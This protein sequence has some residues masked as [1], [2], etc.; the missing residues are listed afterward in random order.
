MVLSI[1]DNGIHPQVP[2]DNDVSPLTQ[3][4]LFVDAT[5]GATV[6]VADTP[7]LPWLTIQAA[8]TAAVAGDKIVVAPGAYAES[9]VIDKDLFI[10]AAGVT[11]LTAAPDIS[12]GTLTGRL[13]KIAYSANGCIVYGDSSDL[14]NGLCL[15][16]AFA[17]GSTIAETFDINMTGAN[18]DIVGRQLDLWTNANSRNVSFNGIGAEPA[19]ITTTNTECFRQYTANN[20]TN[21]DIQNGASAIINGITARSGQDTSGSIQN[22]NASGMIDISG[23]AAKS[24]GDHQ[25]IS[26]FRWNA[27]GTV[28]NEAKMLDISAVNRME[29]HSGNTKAIDITSCPAIILLAGTFDRSVTV[30]DA[31]AQITTD[32]KTVSFDGGLRGVGALTFDAAADGGV[33]DGGYVTEWTHNATVASERLALDN[34]IL[35]N[36]FRISNSTFFF[37]GGSGTNHTVIESDVEVTHSNLEYT[38]TTQNKASGT[39]EFLG[40][41]KHCNFKGATLAF[42]VPVSDNAKILN[43]SF[44][45]FDSTLFPAIRGRNPLMNYGS[46]TLFPTYFFTP[47]TLVFPMA[48]QPKESDGAGGRQVIAD[49]TVFDATIYTLADQAAPGAGENLSNL[50]GLLVEMQVFQD[51]ANIYGFGAG[52]WVIRSTATDAAV[53]DAALSAPG[54]DLVSLL[55][56]DESLIGMAAIDIDLEGT[57]LG[58]GF[59]GQEISVK[60][61]QPEVRTVTADT[62][63]EFNE[64][65]IHAD[66]TAG[67]VDVTCLPEANQQP[68]FIRKTVAGNNVIIKN[69]AGGTI[70]TLTSADQ[71]VEVY[72]DGTTIFTR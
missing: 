67:D 32:D 35:K 43:C 3:N 38:S 37:L 52:T 41:Y 33:Y 4:T 47:N 42:G 69:D 63:V 55:E 26:C 1:T 24:T 23:G 54:S 21:L 27:F 71:T 59:V 53:I 65:T 48:V 60:V 36:A 66:S 10:D 29:I 11:G 68:F 61:N 6:G 5:Y 28:K 8:I 12:S 49:L 14:D 16:S 20:F 72:S 45:G 31:A 62:L 44:T 39:A 17:T 9:L 7:G 15:E 25:H 58:T 46:A 57:D 22:V 51:G 64:K 70:F 40:T 50:E 56:T 2:P 19:I 18:Y 13:G 34:D 30:R